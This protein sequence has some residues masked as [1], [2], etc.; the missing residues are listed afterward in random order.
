MR[1]P[2]G[3]QALSVLFLLFAAVLAT[4]AIWY[5]GLR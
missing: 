5:F 3:R 1:I 4:A 2:R